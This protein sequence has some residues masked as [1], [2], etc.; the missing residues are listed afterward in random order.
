MQNLRNEQIRNTISAKFTTSKT[1][2]LKYIL[3]VSVLTHLWKQ[4]TWEF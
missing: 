2:I 1:Q 4:I 3:L